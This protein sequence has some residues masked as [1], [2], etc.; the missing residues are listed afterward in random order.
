MP[1]W[2]AITLRVIGAGFVAGLAIWCASALA[3]GPLQARMLA[4]G[5]AIIGAV[6]VVSLFLP[7]LRPIALPAFAVALAGFAWLWAGVKPSNDR[8]WQPEAAVLPHA[9]FDGDRVTI[10][11]VRNFDYRSNTDYTPR[12]YDKTYDLRELDSVDLITSYWMGDAVAH[13]ILSFGFNE[14]DFVAFSIETRKQRGERYSALAG[15]FRRYELIYVV[16]DERDLLRLRT[17]YRKSPPEDVYLFRS[18]ASAAVVRRIFV[19][20]L[21]KLNSLA[22]QP[23]FYNT[24]TT[25]CT[26]DVLERTR[27]NPGAIGYSWKVLLSGYAPLFAYEQGRLDSRLPFKELKRRAHINAAARAAD[28]AEDFSQ[29]IRIGMPRPPPA[30]PG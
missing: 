3:L 17:N 16:G 25:N 18:N 23:E 27:I 30:T 1:W 22:A 6:A 24:L 14:R 11:N 8:D 10:H 19:D 21:H 12:Y 15:F 9:T 26:T 13:V 2:L 29:R 7:G 20:Y 4:L 5:M 28:Q